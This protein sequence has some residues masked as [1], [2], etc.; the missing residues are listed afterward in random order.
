MTRLSLFN[1]PLL[2]G[3]E[4]LER[5]VERIAKASP[6][7]YPPYNVEQLA[8]NR[9]RITL[10]VAGFRPEDLKVQV[11]DKQLTIQGKHA[12]SSAASCSATA[13]RSPAPTSTMVCSTSIWSAR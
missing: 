9:L 8:D 6:D 10:A 1:S 12:S 4:D 11:Q 13:W 7:G 2:L 5:A 3:F